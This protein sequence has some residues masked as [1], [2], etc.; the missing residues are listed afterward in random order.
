MTKKFHVLIIDPQRDFCDDE[1]A[2]AVPGA[3]L[4]MYRLSQM[5]YRLSDRIECIHCTLDTHHLFDISHPIFW[6]NDSGE[7]PAPFTII[8]FDAVQQKKWRTTKQEYQS[9]ALEYVMRLDENHRY[10]LCI[11]P[12]HCLIGTS[13]HNVHHLLSEALMEWEEKHK[14]NVNYILKGTNIKTEHYSAVQADVPDPE[15]P[16]T[17][18][19]QSLID[20]LKQAGAILVAGEALSHCVRYTVEDIV[21]QFTPEEVRKIVLLGDCCS[22]VN[23]F[24]IQAEDFV[25]DMVKRGVKVSNSIDFH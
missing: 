12:P 22:A 18:I 21:S 15:D 13:G 16:N 19:N 11:W 5:L 7:H 17:M 20:S 25:N 6:I 1:G 14:A 8:S 10:P 24:E 9:Y 4:D 23:G 2:L 3:H